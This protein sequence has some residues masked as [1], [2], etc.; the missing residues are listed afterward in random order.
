VERTVERRPIV[1]DEDV[2]R[3]LGEV[4]DDYVAPPRQVAAAT[5]NPEHAV[6]PSSDPGDTAVTADA[7]NGPAPSAAPAASAVVIPAAEQGRVEEV[8]RRYARAYG[9][10]DAGAARA[11]WPTVDERALA[12]AFQNLASQ[13]VSFDDCDIDIRGVVA[14]VSCRGQASYVGKVGSREPRTESRTWRFELRR[15][16]DAWKIENAEARRQSPLESSRDQ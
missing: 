1:E 13:N 7:R 12:R 3:P 9:A 4:R 8:L 14:N 2:V 16:G 15:D 10:L 5:P 11:V 6:V